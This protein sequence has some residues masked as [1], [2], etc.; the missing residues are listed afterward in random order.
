[1]TP[2]PSAVPI[3][4][5]AGRRRRPPRTAASIAAACICRIQATGTPPQVPTLSGRACEWSDCTIT[6][7]AGMPV[8][9]ATAWRIQWAPIRSAV[10]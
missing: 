1:M 5:R 6:G 7:S 3:Y 10:L 8:R 2:G 4:T 9:S